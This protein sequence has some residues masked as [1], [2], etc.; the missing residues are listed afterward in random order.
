M[1]IFAKTKD[2]NFK[3]ITGKILSYTIFLKLIIICLIISNWHYSSRILTIQ[4]EVI[5][6]I[7]EKD[8]FSE[9]NFKQYLM[10]LNVKFPDVA[11]AQAKLETANFTSK[12]FKENNN[13]FGMRR[14]SARPTTSSEV[15]S[16]YASYKNWRLS[17]QDFCFF[18]AKYLSDL[19]KEDYLDYLGKNYAEDPS[20]SKK[21]L[22]LLN[23]GKD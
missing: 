3:N 23:N 11:F 5:L 8:K 6:S 21:I 1:K 10:E 19:S 12:I 16:G 13:L 14:S 4:N 9:D 20:Y 18:N 7:Q 2:L 22:T 15:E 17:V